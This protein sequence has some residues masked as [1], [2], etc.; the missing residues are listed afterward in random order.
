MLF[1]RQDVKRTLFKV[2]AEV[3]F[4]GAI[5]PHI[6]LAHPPPLKSPLYEAP[7]IISLHDSPCAASA[8]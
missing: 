1:S 3:C 7:W 5:V 6:N 2:S 8:H 4:L